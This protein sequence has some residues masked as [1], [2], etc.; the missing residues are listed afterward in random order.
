[1]PIRAIRD[2]TGAAWV[3]AVLA[4]DVAAA[5]AIATPG[6]PYFLTRDLSAL[7]AGL[8]AFCRGRR[9]AGLVASAGAK[10]LRAEALGVQ[11]AGIEDWFLNDWPDI[12]SSEALETFC[13]E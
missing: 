9:R 8:R 10:R 12:R 4:G 1:M 6:L 5:A 13:T 11:V 2:Q 7:R 3:E